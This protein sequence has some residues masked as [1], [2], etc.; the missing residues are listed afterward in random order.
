MDRP[1]RKLGPSHRRLY[2]YYGSVEALAI[3]L[4]PNDLIAVFVAR[5][6]IDLDRDCSKDPYFESYVEL[7]AK[8]DARKRRHLPRELR[9]LYKD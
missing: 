2:H 9:R 1:S 5:D 8:L 3:R 6:H 4:Y 7:Q